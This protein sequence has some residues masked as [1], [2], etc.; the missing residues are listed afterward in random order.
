MKQKFLSF[1]KVVGPKLLGVFCVVFGLVLIGLFFLFFGVVVTTVINFYATHLK[2]YFDTIDGFVEL[3]VLISL[4]LSISR[5]CRV[6]A[7]TILVFCSYILALS[8][9]LDSLLYT[10]SSFGSVGVFVGILFVGIGVY[11]LG[12]VALLQ[13]H[14]FAI[15]WS[16]LVGLLIIFG[17][18]YLGIYIV[19]NE[20]KKR[21][22]LNELEESDTFESE[23]S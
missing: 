22:V 2:Q 21:L 11:V 18:R 23:E 15:F 4:L 12:L 6:W 7:G 16:V 14:A 17:I 13:V 8:L 9:W 3:F 19:G 1:Y 20:E 10:Y 5:K